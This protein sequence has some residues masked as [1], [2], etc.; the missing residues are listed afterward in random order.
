MITL[1]SPSEDLSC[2]G[3]CPP[4]RP[5][6]YDHLA[7][8][9]ILKREFRENRRR[10]PENIARRKPIT[11]F[12]CWALGYLDS[13][14]LRIGCMLHPKANGGEDLRHIT[15][16]GAKCAR[17]SC[18]QAG[19]FDRLSHE[20][21]T[22]WLEPSQ[23][24]SP[25][26]YSSPEANPL[27]HLLF[28]HEEVLGL[29]YEYA[30]ARG[31][32]CTELLWHVPF[33][34]ERRIH[35]RAWRMVVKRVIQ[36]GLNSFALECLPWEEIFSGFRKEVEK[37]NNRF[38]RSLSLNRSLYVHRLDMPGDFKDFLKF[39]LKKNVIEPENAVTVH[40]HFSGVIE[41]IMDRLGV[42]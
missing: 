22:F 8:V 36:S 3:C 6:G 38:F 32:S 18:L 31:W 39:F 10:L 7:Y 35:P 17:E 20:Q 1:C 19:I 16:Y 34:L 12:S 25:F 29:F 11:G 26:F 4:I 23:G 2:F 28:W 37:I 30:T 5:A 27:F 15:G 9:R 24:L 21:K 33:L 40:E 13:R 41:D 42:R 14:F